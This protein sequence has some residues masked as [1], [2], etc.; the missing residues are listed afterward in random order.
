MP[1]LF[2]LKSF[3]AAIRVGSLATAGPVLAGVIGAVVAGAGLTGCG[4]GNFGYIPP[5]TTPITPVPPVPYTGPTFTVKVLAGTTPLAGSAVQFYF[6]GTTGSGSAATALLTA[7]VQTDANGNAAVP[8]NYTCPSSTGMVYLKATGGTAS[9]TSINAN[10]VLV[11]AV[12]A[13]STVAAGATYVVD[14]ATTVAAAYALEGFYAGGSIGASATNLAGITNAFAT[15]ATLAD[16]V[17]GT[18]PGASLPANAA[19]PALR[20]DALANA[21]NA[22]V[23]QA[24]ACTALYAEAPTGTP[25]NTFEAMY[26]LARY[27]AKNVGAIYAQSLLS[28]AYGSGLAARPLDWSVFLTLSGGGLSYPSG[29]G[30]DSAGNVWVASYFYAAS[31]FT[32][33]G[34]PVFAAGITGY[35]L[36]NSYG[37]AIDLQNRVWIPNEQPYIADGTIGSVSVFT[38]SGSTLT[39]VNSYTAG[40]INFPL[41]V[42]IDPNGTTWVVDYGN[43][44]LTLLNSSGAALSGPAGYTTPLFAFPDVVAVDANHYGWVGNLASTMVTKVAPDGSSFTN[45]DCCNGAA[46]IALDQGNNVWVADY[47]GDSVSLISS[48][49][50]VVSNGTYTGSAS[51]DRPQG[52]AVDGAGT[53]FVANFLQPYL[54]VLSGVNAGPGQSLT[55]ATG[56]GG[57]ANLLKPFALAIDA[58]GNVWVSNQANATV[59][60]FIGL[61]VPVKTPLS[62]LPKAP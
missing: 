4:I 20:I 42:A 16:P 15:A 28:S 13:C 59:T 26:D 18:S 58:S 24:A 49:G 36:N 11:G 2:P 60:K 10:T 9:S 54:S 62:G 40:G 48:G 47:Y 44:H 17:A 5:S 25:P 19:S 34:T 39:N 29:L 23:L 8:A 53:V 21:L 31:E 14:E 55:P 12:G 32:P 38:A 37:L 33:I 35:G 45:Y 22:C 30:V 51:I 3:L 52:I 1:K 7:A 56:L 61:A 46:G 50:Q 6:A 41:S 27:P 43:S 57:D